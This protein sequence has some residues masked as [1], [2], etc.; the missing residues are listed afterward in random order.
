MLENNKSKLSET[1][2]HLSEIK[3]WHW[4]A[5]GFIIFPLQIFGIIKAVRHI[6]RK[7]V[8]Q[9][10]RNWIFIVSTFYS[11]GIILTVLLFTLR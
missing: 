2:R 8:S 7:D 3:W 11:F 4:I 9:V 10:E 6:V 5:A 1:N